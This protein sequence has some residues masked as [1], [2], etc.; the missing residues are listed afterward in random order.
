MSTRTLPITPFRR[1]AA[2][3]A[4]V[5]VAS[6][7]IAGPPAAAASTA[8]APSCA[9]VGVADLMAARLAGLGRDGFTWVVVDIPGGSASTDFGVREVR[10]SPAVPCALVATVVNHEWMHTRQEQLFGRYVGDTFPGAEL[11]RVAD[12]GSWL[13]GSEDTPYLTQGAPGVPP[14][15]CTAPELNYARRLISTAPT[16]PVVVR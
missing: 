3:L 9:P 2:C 1:A 6:A 4:V 7:L 12:C 10:V 15:P 8:S 11:E 16:H 13:L 5:V 14:G